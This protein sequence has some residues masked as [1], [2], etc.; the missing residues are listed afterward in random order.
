[1]IREV[2]LSKDAAEELHCC[3]EFEGWR[4]KASEFLGEWR[5]GNEWR[6]II[7]NE[8]NECYATVYR[9][10]AGD[11][12]WHSWQDVEEVTFTRVYPREV[13]TIE[14]VEAE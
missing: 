4:L 6:L 3:E 9:D 12:E 11:G 14:Y 7:A 13:M 2:T 5:W 1:V 10:S 8:D